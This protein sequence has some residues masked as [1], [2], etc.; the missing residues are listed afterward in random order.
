MRSR[1]AF[2]VTLIALVAL[3]LLFGYNC[4]RLA[5]EENEDI[6]VRL[7]ITA[8]PSANITRD[9]SAEDRVDMLKDLSAGQR[10][11]FGLF[12]GEGEPV[13]LSDGMHAEIYDPG[14]HPSR[15]PAR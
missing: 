12:N 1:V 2:I 8:P 14:R 11:V 9:A 7:R 13:Y 10:T 5:D 15:K 4:S 3:A 6:R